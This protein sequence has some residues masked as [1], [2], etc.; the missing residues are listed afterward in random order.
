MPLVSKTANGKH[1]EFDPTGKNQ[2]YFYYRALVRQG[3]ALSFVNQNGVFRIQ[4]ESNEV[5]E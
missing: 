1:F 3:K 4:A 2:F 5:Q